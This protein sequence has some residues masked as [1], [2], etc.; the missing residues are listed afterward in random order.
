MK[1]NSRGGLVYSTE[2]GRTCPRCRQAID[3]CTCGAPVEPTAAAGTPVRVQRDRK[4]RAG[5]TVTV[6]S[7]IPLPALGLARLCQTLKA[8]CGAGGTVKG[9]TIEVQGD[10]MDTVV[11]V[12]EAEG[13]RVKRVGG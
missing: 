9:N 10:H 3:A 4:G 6:I 5:K 11:T 8:R 13:F 7:D 12:L 2:V 1:R